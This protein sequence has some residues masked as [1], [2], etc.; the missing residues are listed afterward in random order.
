MI[1]QL[2][3]WP[4]GVYKVNARK[5]PFGQKWVTRPPQVVTRFFHPSE[6]RMQGK[7]LPPSSSSSSPSSAGHSCLMHFVRQPAANSGFSSHKL[8]CAPL[9]SV[10]QHS[11]KHAEASPFSVMS[12]P[13]LPPERQSHMQ[14]A[15]HSLRLSFCELPG[16]IRSHCSRQSG[17]PLLASH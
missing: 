13:P 14:L 11:L 16:Y 7:L 5:V 10:V 15:T 8:Y 3:V 6:S 12:L 2:H 17:A 9:R 1:M 4:F